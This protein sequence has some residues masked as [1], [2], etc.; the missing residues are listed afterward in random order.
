MCCV[1]YFLLGNFWVA[2]WPLRSC[3]FTRSYLFVYLLSFLQ[4]VKTYLSSSMCFSPRV[5]SN[6]F[7]TL[8]TVAQQAPLSMGYP[9]QEYWSGLPFLSPR[10][11]PDPGMETISPAL[12]VV[13]CIACRFFTDWVTREALSFFIIKKME[14]AL[15]F[16]TASLHILRILCIVVLLLNKYQ[17]S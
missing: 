3:Y 14:I 10:D 2:F 6:S 17:V 15:S 1:L 4:V 8:W 12:Q 13:S 11:L 7:E 16:I 9:K 5:M